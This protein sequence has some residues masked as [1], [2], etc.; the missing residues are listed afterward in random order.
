MTDEE[1]IRLHAILR[2]RV[3][4]VGFRAFVVDKG[5]ALG[6]TGWARNRWDGSVEVVAEAER[7]TLE[8]LLRA[9][10][11]GPRMANVSEVEQEWQTASGEFK[12]FRV[13]PT[14]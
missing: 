3:Q 14:I 7:S 1:R 4:G 5:L 11:R 6:A 12:S 2:G 9:L 13:K 10:Q 8:E